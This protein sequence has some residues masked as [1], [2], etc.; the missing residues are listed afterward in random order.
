MSVVCVC[1]L[2]G[3]NA[4][5][6]FFPFLSLSLSL[7]SLSNSKAPSEVSRNFLSF[8]PTLES[9]SQAAHFL[10][11][12]IRVS[13]Y[14]AITEEETDKLCRYIKEFIDQESGGN[15]TESG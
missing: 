11:I 7:P 15:K 4:N 14:N 3:T 1:A 10:M 9:W 12:G 8:I 13:L 2:K 6:L 5:D